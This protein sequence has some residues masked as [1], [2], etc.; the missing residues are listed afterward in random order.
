MK[1]ELRND[2]VILEGYVNAVCRDSKILTDANGKFVE[3]VMPKTFTRAIEK[4]SVDILLN[5]DKSRKLGDTTTNLKLR[6]D[7]IGLYARAEIS[8]PDV[9]HRAKEGNLNGWSFGFLMNKD[10][11]ENTN[12]EG[13][14]RRF[15]EDIT[16]KEVSIL[17][18][19]TPAYNGT[20]IQTRD[21]E[22]TYELRCFD[23]EIEI[24]DNTTKEEEREFVNYDHIEAKTLIL[25]LKQRHQ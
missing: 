1:V 14:E 18:G 13:L 22:E 15:L 10:R 17:S 3:Q 23:D 21:N 25:K 19:K 5:H 4:N 9:I 12:T 24:I 6:E 7:N 2:S 16:L 20:S 11:K 8:D